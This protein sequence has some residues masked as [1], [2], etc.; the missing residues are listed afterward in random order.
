MHI[1]KTRYLG[2][3]MF[4]SARLMANV[5]PKISVLKKFCV[6]S[7]LYAVFAKLS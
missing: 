6:Y 2:L 3:Y 4:S 7:T 5:W 1:L